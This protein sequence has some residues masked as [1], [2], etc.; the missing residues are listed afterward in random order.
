MYN[1]QSMANLISLGRLIDTSF[2]LYKKYWKEFLGISLW[3]IVASLPRLVGNLLSP[4]GAGPT[5]TF[6]DWVSFGFSLIGSVVLAVATV[7]VFI[8][9]IQLADTRAKGKS[10][11]FKAINK[12]SWKLFLPYI[13]VSLLALGIIAGVSLLAAPGIALLTASSL[14]ENFSGGLAALGI[15]LFFVGGLAAFVLLVKSSLELGLAQF[16]LVV[17]GKRGLAAIKT[18]FSLINGRWWATFV[19]Y[20]APKL[21]YIFVIV[22]L[23]FLIP[24]A[25]ALLAVVLAPTSTILTK[26]VYV[27]AYL[28]TISLSA[29]STPL[30]VVTD[31]VLY[32]SLR[33]SK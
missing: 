3:L 12:Q 8:S 23:Q 19:R 5:V 10:P 29:V 28:F 13:V 31:Y 33:A 30:I 26:L 24:A 17:D 1:Q 21:L 14:Q 6:G 32:D 9:L 11:D 7:W 15:V 18:C 20:V 2:D 16:A 25:L 4:L 22:L 27:A